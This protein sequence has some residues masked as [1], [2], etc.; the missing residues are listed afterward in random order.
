MENQNIYQSIASIMSDVEAIGKNK[1]NSQQGFMYRGIDDLYNDLQPKFAKH[2]VFIASEVLDIQREERQSKNGGFLLWTVAKIRFTFY[3]IDGSSVSSIM[4]GEA[5]D[6]GDKG[7]NK[8]MSIAL[9]YCLFQL[10]LIPTEDVKKSDPDSEVHEVKSKPVLDYS[11][12]EMIQSWK[13]LVSQQK[14]V[15]DLG[16][17]YRQNKK[18]VDGNSEIKSLFSTRKKQLENGAAVTA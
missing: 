6:S 12:D 10:L 16:A 2:G 5:M 9:K 4:I 8:A 15:E 3:A 1:K 7:A 14:S 17:I 18:V 11:H 13:D